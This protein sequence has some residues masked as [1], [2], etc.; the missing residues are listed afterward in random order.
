MLQYI[1]LKNNQIS[2]IEDGAFENNK[3][4][5]SLDVSYNNL[6]SIYNLTVGSEINLNYNLLQKIKVSS[7]FTKLKFK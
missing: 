3:D 1:T 5:F 6:T 7:T 2:M 4:L